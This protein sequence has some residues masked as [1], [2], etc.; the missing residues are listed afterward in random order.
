MLYICLYYFTMIRKNSEPKK[1]PETLISGAFKSYS[2]IPRSLFCLAF[3]TK[4]ADDLVFVE[5]FHLVACRTKIFARVE[6]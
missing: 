2:A 1:A 5:F 3:R 4:H 6:L